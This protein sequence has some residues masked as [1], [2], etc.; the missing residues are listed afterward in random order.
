MVGYRIYVNGALKKTITSRGS[1]TWTNSGEKK[2]KKYVYKV[3]AY[4]AVGVSPAA[5]LTKKRR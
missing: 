3:V 4:N 5:T 2:G 1:T